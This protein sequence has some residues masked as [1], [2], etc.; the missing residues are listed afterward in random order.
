[1]GGSYQINKDGINLDLIKI[2]GLYLKIYGLLT[3]LQPWVDA[4]VSG[5]MVG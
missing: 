1:M 4:W 5:Q 3:L 2:I